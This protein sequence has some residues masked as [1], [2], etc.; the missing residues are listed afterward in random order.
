MG[1][2][3]DD[4]QMSNVNLSQPSNVV[5]IQNARC[6][7][8][9]NL[10]SEDVKIHGMK[11]IKVTIKWNEEEGF[12]YLDPKFGSYKHISELEVPEGEIVE[13]FCP[14]CGKSLKNETELC[15]SC[16][17]PTFT[18]DLPDE[19]EITGCLK[20]GCFGHTLKIVSFESMHLQIDEE[21]VKVIM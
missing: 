2:R 3:L 9:C 21:F 10:M 8:G 19:G 14:E 12:I 20:K 6:P 16:S 4:V 18:L 1:K 13:F 5:H 17:S 15:R 7:N 11:S